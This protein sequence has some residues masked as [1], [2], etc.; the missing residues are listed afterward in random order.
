MFF[1]NLDWHSTDYTAL[2]PRHR[3]L[4]DMWWLAVVIDVHLVQFQKCLT[5]DGPF[6]FCHTTSYTV[7]VFSWV[8]NGIGK[9]LS[10]RDCSTLLIL[11]HMNGWT[12]LG[13]EITLPLGIQNEQN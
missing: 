9:E 4:N 2:Y 12:E 6:K 13:S 1:Q 5:L 3:Y 8:L 7:C 10:N 11:G